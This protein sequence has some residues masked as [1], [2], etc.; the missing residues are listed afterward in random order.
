MVIWEVYFDNPR[1]RPRLLQENPMFVYG[2]Q[3]WPQVEKMAGFTFG[4]LQN[5]EIYENLLYLTDIPILRGT[6]RTCFEHAN[7]PAVCAGVVLAPKGTAA[8]EC[9]H[10]MRGT[11]PVR[12]FPGTPLT[13]ILYV[14]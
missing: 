4:L 8:V 6:V 11:H 9:S 13:C 14:G 1:I 10:D 2:L 12:S 3:P 7:Q 5:W